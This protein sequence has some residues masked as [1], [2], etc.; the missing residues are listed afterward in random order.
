MYLYYCFKLRAL[1]RGGKRGIVASLSKGESLSTKEGGLGGEK[2]IKSLSSLV[3]S[4]SL[5]SLVTS[6]SVVMLRG[7][8][9]RG[10]R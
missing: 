2:I 6:L 10:I 9:A 5:F 4:L 3:M 1:G 8:A 7:V